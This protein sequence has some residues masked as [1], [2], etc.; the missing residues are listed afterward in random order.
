[1]NFKVKTNK[2]AIGLYVVSKLTNGKRHTDKDVS[3][4]KN[5]CSF[6]F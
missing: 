1:M 5:I 2:K 4:A 6:L 3:D